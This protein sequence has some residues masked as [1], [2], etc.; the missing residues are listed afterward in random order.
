MLFMCFVEFLSYCCHARHISLRAKSF[1]LCDISAM[2]LITLL[3]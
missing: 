1:V 3:M 2:S